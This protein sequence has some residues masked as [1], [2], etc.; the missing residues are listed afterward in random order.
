MRT[1]NWAEVY[2]GT[3]SGA[4][5]GLQ[6]LRRLPRLRALPWTIAIGFPFTASR[7]WGRA[8]SGAQALGRD[9]KLGALWES[10]EGAGGMAALVYISAH[11]SLLEYKS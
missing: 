4:W 10:T 1:E 5:Y 7:G 11:Y 6:R 8:C 9:Q 3:L 2:A